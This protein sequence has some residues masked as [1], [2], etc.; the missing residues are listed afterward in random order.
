MTDHN[1]V[2]GDV[3]ARKYRVERVLGK[4]GMGVVVAATHIEL[5]QLVVFISGG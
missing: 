2:A 4:G 1:I 3:L 5:G